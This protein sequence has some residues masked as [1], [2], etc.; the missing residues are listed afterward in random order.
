[1]P[2]PRRRT[3]REPSVEYGVDGPRLDARIARE[4]PAVLLIAGPNGAGKTT[5]ALQILP[6]AL[7]LIEFVNADEIARGLSPLNPTGADEAAG[8]I[9]IARMRSLIG[10]G[11]SFAFESTLAGTGWL[12]ILERASEAGYTTHILFLHLSSDRLAIARVK[13]RAL[14]GG[15]DVPAAVVRR[16]YQRG[17]QNLLHQEFDGF[18]TAVVCDNSQAA[19]EAPPLIAEKR[20]RGAFRIHDARRWNS[21]ARS[22]DAT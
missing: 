11:R 19:D 1:M 18:E 13:R 17:L 7:D 15:H 6:S 21:I 12:R 14:A 2:P 5:I 4:M 20:E 22:I 10:A 3:L 16:R 9:M 8:R